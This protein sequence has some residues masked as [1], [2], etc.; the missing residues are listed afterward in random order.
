V[1]TFQPS[2]DGSGNDP[3]SALQLCLNLYTEGLI[4]KMEYDNKRKEILERI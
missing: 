1:L 3:K 2:D 4:T